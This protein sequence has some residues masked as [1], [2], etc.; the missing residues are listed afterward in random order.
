MDR[1][2]RSSPNRL[3][4]QYLGNTKRTSL[5]FHFITIYAQ[6]QAPIYPNSTISATW[7][8]KWTGY[9]FHFTT[10]HS[11][12][13]KAPLFPNHTIPA[14]WDTKWTSFI[15][16]LTTIYIQIQAL[17]YQNS[18]IP[19]TWNTKWTGLIFH[20]PLY[21][22]INLKLHFIQIHTFLSFGIRNERVW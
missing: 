11:N 3:L 18:T 13:F 19:T 7:N 6:I 16:Q 15:L 10:I 2:F 22:Q 20:L 14:T 5:T 17:L 21:I 1:Q 8:T 4:C 12:K 9:I